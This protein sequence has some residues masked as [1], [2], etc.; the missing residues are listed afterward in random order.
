MQDLSPSEI[1]ALSKA[2]GKAPPANLSKEMLHRPSSYEIGS[3]TQPNP[4]SVS[5]AQFSHLQ[6]ASTSEPLPQER[7]SEIKIPLQG[8]LGKIKLPLGELMKLHNG[9]IIQLDKLAGELI[10]VVD[11]NGKVI[12][13]GEVV[14]VNE[15]YG[16]RILETLA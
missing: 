10:D 7:F 5:H 3:G 16:I 13:K 6:D 8:V 14:V 4:N 2:M 12:A 1:E 11:G 9:S 15:Y